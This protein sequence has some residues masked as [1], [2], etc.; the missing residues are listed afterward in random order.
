MNKRYE[1]WDCKIVVEITDKER[2]PGFDSPPRMAA[3]DA[4]VSAGLNVVMCAS[5]WGGTLSERDKVYIAHNSSGDPKKAMYFAGLLDS[6]ELPT[7]PM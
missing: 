7:D 3:I 6:K 2:P 4:V 1:V 5:G